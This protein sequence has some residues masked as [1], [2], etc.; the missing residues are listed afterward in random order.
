MSKPYQKTTNTKNDHSKI[1]NMQ[2]ESILPEDLKKEINDGFLADGIL[3]ENLVNLIENY[4]KIL[5][6]SDITQSSIR[7]IYD[8]FKSLQMRLQQEFV[9]NIQ[10]NLEDLDMKETEADA[11]RRISPMIRLMKNKSF[12]AIE[13]KKNDLKKNDEKNKKNYDS[14]KDFIEIAV[15]NVKSKKDYDAFMDLFECIV[16]NL[17]KGE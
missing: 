15:N 6:N 8:S 12:Y 10:N 7:N 2:S 9:K 14:L 17:K 4:A 3:K 5:R 1:Q 16:A 13:K 11:Y